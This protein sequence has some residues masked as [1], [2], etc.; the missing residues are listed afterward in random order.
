MSRSRRS[1][2]GSGG[3]STISILQSQEVDERRLAV[4]RK[5]VG[6]DQREQLGQDSRGGSVIGTDDSARTATASATAGINRRR[7]R[8]CGRCRGGQLRQLLRRL[9]RVERETCM[10]E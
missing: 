7:R 10:M 1:S 2:S 6:V 4:G 3:G 5:A 8:R 9:Q